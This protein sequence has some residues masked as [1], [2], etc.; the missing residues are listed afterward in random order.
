MALTTFATQ[1]GSRKCWPKRLRAIMPVLLFDFLDLFLA[2]PEVMADLVN[3]R[4]RNRCDKVFVVV[5]GAFVRS[6]E[7][8]DAIRQRV[9]VA[10]VALMQRGA[11]I[12]P[13]RRLRLA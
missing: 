13:E 10:P 5:G 9:A 8:Q 1:A 11:C 3:E 2:H 12:Q 6:L 7:D 4:F